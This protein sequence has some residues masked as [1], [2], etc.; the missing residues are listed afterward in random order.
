LGLNFPN[1]T[2]CARYLRVSQ[3]TVSNALK[4]GGKLGDITIEVIN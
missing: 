4:G 1:Q 2:A 3:P